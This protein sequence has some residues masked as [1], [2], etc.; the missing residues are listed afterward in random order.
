VSGLFVLLAA[1]PAAAQTRV[2]YNDRPNSVRL[3]AG[4]FEPDGSSHYWRQ[5][6]SDF[7]GSA[8][9]FEDTILGIDYVHMLS[10]RVGVMATLT[11][12]EG[13]DRQAFRDFV[14]EQGNDILHDTSLEITS[15]EGGVLYYF[16]RRNA[17][18]SPYIGGGGG[19]VD[20]E[21]TLGRSGRALRGGTLDLG[22]GR[23]EERL[24]RLRPYRSRGA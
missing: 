3:W 5:R 18:V 4:Q 17:T 22:R 9:D 23:L 11:G 15:F 6:A 21:L 20:F 1:V 10:E 2:P 7:T 16:R 13:E 12:W 14:D 24:R 8:S 19:F